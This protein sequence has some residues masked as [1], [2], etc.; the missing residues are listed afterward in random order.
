MAAI[1]MGEQSVLYKLAFSTF[2]FLLLLH[3]PKTSAL[4]LREP[5]GDSSYLSQCGGSHD[6]A[7]H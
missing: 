6:P 3:W 4:N 7:L 1:S 2:S 5:L